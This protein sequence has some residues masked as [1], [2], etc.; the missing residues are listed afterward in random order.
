MRAN[1]AIPT[2]GGGK[3]GWQTEYARRCAEVRTGQQMNTKGCRAAPLGT[4]LHLVRY[5]RKYESTIGMYGI[6]K[7]YTDQ[8]CIYETQSFV[9]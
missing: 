8:V 2:A 7:V 1:A 4:A 5:I 3:R 6:A 9:L